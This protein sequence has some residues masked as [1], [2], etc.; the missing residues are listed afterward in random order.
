MFSDLSGQSVP[1][2]LQDP[3]EFRVIKPVLKHEFMKSSARRTLCLVSDQQCDDTLAMESMSAT[4]LEAHHSV[5]N[6]VDRKQRRLEKFVHA[7]TAIAI[8]GSDFRC[9][10]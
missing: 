1:R 4:A 7:N 9:Y 10:L 2:I 3:S 8:L 6:I 5:F